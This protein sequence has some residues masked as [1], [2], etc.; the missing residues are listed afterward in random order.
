MK[1][2]GELLTDKKTKDMLK[3]ADIENYLKMNFVFYLII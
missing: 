1:E 3:T 2:L